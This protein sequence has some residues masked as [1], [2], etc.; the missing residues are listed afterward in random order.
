M[1]KFLFKIIQP[2]GGQTDL[3]LQ[4]AHGFLASMKEASDSVAQLHFCLVHSGGSRVRRQ[5]PCHTLDHY[6]VFFFFT[7]GP[8]Y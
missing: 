4:C 1:N 3:W 5:L 7:K 2:A 8:D 6:F